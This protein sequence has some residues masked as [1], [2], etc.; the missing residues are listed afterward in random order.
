[1]AD[2]AGDQRVVMVNDCTETS[3]VAMRKV[4]VGT[5]TVAICETLDVRLEIRKRHSLGVSR[6]NSTL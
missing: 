4:C 1:M 2:A 5:L 6:C 3:T